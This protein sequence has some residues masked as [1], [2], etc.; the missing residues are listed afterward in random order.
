MSSDLKNKSR[1]LSLILRHDPGVIGISVDQHGWAE[2]AD[3][4]ATA[5]D[6]ITRDE[7]FEI[8]ASSD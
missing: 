7:I 4:L 2:I 1:F 5:P 8:A 3:I 6:Q